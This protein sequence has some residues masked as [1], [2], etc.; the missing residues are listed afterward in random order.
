MEWH[1]TPA[2]SSNWARRSQYQVSRIWNGVTHYLISWNEVSIKLP[3]DRMILHTNLKSSNRSKPS[4]Y[5]ISNWWNDITH[6][7]RV[8]IGPKRLSMESIAHGIWWLTR[9]EFKSAE[10]KSA[11]NWIRSR[12]NGITH[13]LKSSNWPKRSQYGM[14]SLWNFITHV[15]SQYWISTRRNDITCPLRVQTG[16]RGEFWI[17]SRC[18]D[19]TH[20]LSLNWVK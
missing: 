9:W 8:Q 11:S 19:S 20:C 7:L 18:N 17:S 4:Q 2:E 1:Y 6:L 16:Q 13:V 14:N 3:V 15:Q 5:R 10:T 12:W